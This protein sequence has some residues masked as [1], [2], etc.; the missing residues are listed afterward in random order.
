MHDTNDS[1]KTPAA[2][3]KK[4]P[5]PLYDEWAYDSTRT[6]NLIQKNIYRK[7]VKF[8]YPE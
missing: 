5:E 4:A 2:W 6:E 7:A 3:R 1:W 8:F